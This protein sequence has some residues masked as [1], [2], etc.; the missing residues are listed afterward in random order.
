M[1]KKHDQRRVNRREFI[2]QAGLCTAAV[3][4]VSGAAEAQGAAEPP[5][6][7]AKPAELLP[8]I[9]LGS[10]AVRYTEYEGAE[11]NVWDRTYD[12]AEVVEWLLRQR[13]S[14]RPWWQFWK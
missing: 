6:A 7:A 9:Q 3:A 14:G 4:A 5:G 12:N 11:H 10:R 13:R 1:D 2:G 8:T